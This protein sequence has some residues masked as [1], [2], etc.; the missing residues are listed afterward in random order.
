MTEGGDKIQTIGSGK[1]D[2]EILDWILESNYEGPIGILDHRND[3]DAKESLQQNIEGLERL[4]QS[5]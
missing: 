5:K 1:R 2:A 3:M 4:L